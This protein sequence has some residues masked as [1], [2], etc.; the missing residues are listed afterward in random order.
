MLHQ[1]ITS[2]DALQDGV[3]LFVSA[4]ALVNSAFLAHHLRDHKN[5]R[6]TESSERRFSGALH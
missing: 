6:E 5:W 4:I 2:H 1:L 3:L